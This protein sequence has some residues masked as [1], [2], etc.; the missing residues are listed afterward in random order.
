MLHDGPYDFDRQTIHPIE[1]IELRAG[2][3]ID[4]E[5]RY[6]NYTDST[7]RFGDSSL[8]EMCFL[9]L[10]RYPAATSSRSI[11]CPR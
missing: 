5:C 7:V 6:D 2:D 9:G 11:F 8:A 3:T 4:I 10:F 1:A